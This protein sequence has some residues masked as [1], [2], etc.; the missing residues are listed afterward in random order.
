VS[1]NALAKRTDGHLDG[2]SGKPGPTS[3]MRHLCIK[4]GL[5]QECT[6][7]TDKE[8]SYEEPDVF[9]KRTPEKKIPEESE[10]ERDLALK[11]LFASNGPADDA[12]DDN[13]VSDSTGSRVRAVPCTFRS[14]A[15]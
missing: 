2:P 8:T 6:G 1:S 9:A 5:T 4:T 7:G 13:T 11:S 12:S 10:N 14:S 3:R 15:R